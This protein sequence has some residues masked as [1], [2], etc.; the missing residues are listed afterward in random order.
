MNTADG[1]QSS[2]RGDEA[3]A[4]RVLSVAAI[5]G[6]VLY[7]I[8]ETVLH[9]LRPEFNPAER[10]LSEY[11]VGQFGFLGTTAFWLLAG[12]TSAITV[13]LALEVRRSWWL[14]A[15]CGLL[16]IVSL[17]FC[18]LALFPTDLMGPHGG[19]PPVRT[20][21]GIMHDSCTVIL[22]SALALAALTLPSAYKHDPCWRAATSKIR[23]IGIFIPLFLCIASVVPAEWRGA[24]QRFAVASGLI[25]IV[26]NGWLLL[27]S[28][29]VEAGK[30]VGPRTRTTAST[31]ES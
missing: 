20:A 28:A 10:F 1:C 4:S 12:T 21:T 7:C 16:S 27:R 5:T 17:G 6:A 13:A 24:G 9:I 18:A 31:M 22:S 2:H 29:E 15:T 23:L 25:W 11:A 8:T 26:A 19:P 30:S 3:R 14:I